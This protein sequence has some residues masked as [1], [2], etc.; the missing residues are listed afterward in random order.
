MLARY[1]A[2]NARGKP[3]RYALDPAH[4]EA[5][6]RCVGPDFYLKM[7]PHYLESGGLPREHADMLREAALGQGDPM[8]LVGLYDSAYK[9]RTLGDDS[10]PDPFDPHAWSKQML[11]TAGDTSYHRAQGIY[12]MWAAHHILQHY[13]IP[14][15]E[16]LGISG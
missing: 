16:K 7:L 8:A 2:Q 14:A 4:A 11:G 5:I 10:T 6:R 13:A 15:L 12:P 1:L 9:L 3:V